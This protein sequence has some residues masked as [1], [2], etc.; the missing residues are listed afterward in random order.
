MLSTGLNLSN[1]ENL[2]ILKLTWS[3][4]SVWMGS[5]PLS[6]FPL[7]DD[8]FDFLNFPVIKNNN[9]YNHNY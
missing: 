2:S 3:K 1:T 8:A 4:R 6:P 5:G 7:R 9:N